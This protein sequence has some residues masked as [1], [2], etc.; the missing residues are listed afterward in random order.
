MQHHVRIMPEHCSNF[1]PCWFQSSGAWDGRIAFILE[2]EQPLCAPLDCR[3]RLQRRINSM[4]HSQK[5][6]DITTVTQ[7]KLAG[8]KNDGLVRYTNRIYKWGMI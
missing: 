1:Q 8:R 2:F 7:G 6:I 5:K 3:L 4:L